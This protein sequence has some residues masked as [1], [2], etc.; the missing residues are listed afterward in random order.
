MKHGTRVTRILVL[1]LIA[2]V[3]TLLGQ[4]PSEAISLTQVQQVATGYAHACALT[5]AGNAYCWGWGAEGELGDGASFGGATQS[6]VPVL[7]TGNHTFTSLATGY[8]DVCGIT[9]TQDAYCWGGDNEYV[10]GD[11]DAFQD[12]TSTP[13][14]VAG[15]L[16]WLQLTVGYSV[17]CGIDTNHDAYC[18]GRDA[19]GQ[20][21]NGA[22]IDRTAPTLV[23]GSLN[24]STISAAG[25]AVCGVAGTAAYCWGDNT[26]GQG[27]DGSQGNS[28]GTPTAVSGSYTWASVSAGGGA[29]CGVTTSGTGYCWG[30]GGGVGALGTGNVDT[31]TPDVVAGSHTW[32]SIDAGDGVT[33]GVTTADQAY[34]WGANGLGAL[35]DGTWANNGTPSGVTGNYAFSTLA[36][37]GGGGCGVTN[38]G[39]LYCWGWD[40][41]GSLG[42]DDTT[43]KNHPVGVIGFANLE[44]G[45]NVSAVVDPSLSFSVGNRSSACNGELNFSG[46]AGSATAVAL[47][48]VAGGA[49]VSGGQ[50]LSIAGNAG[51]GFAVYIRGTQGS[52]NLRSS[53][54]PWADVSGTYAAPAILGSGERF[55]FTFF[56][57]TASTSVP[58][59]SAASFIALDSVDRAVMGSTTSASGSACVSFDAQS[60]SSTPAGAYQATV[61]YT[62]VPAF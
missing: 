33:C 18:W 53:G 34:C 40:A 57:S 11:G 8:D 37:G 21:G 52:N 39:L 50:T 26:Y 35:G 10:L 13:R 47:G 12:T 55:G 17:A 15:G 1:C 14:L 4:S 31:P 54:H 51:G 24:W 22:H 49:N 30:S 25:S 5:L 58:I 2:P 59:P 29:T 9:D 48:H 28:H 16:H 42:D 41:K 61:I 19:L 43:N 32:R 60:A 20:L 23:S 45:S 44:I 36:T 56:D 3:L 7:V 62:A 46:S 6:N 27:G 38:V